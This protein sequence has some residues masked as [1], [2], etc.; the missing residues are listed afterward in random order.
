MTDILHLVA[1]EAMRQDTS[2]NPYRTGS[3]PYVAWDLRKVATARQAV[4]A[5]SRN[6]MVGVHRAPDT[7]PAPR[8]VFAWSGERT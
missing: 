5:W 3:L 1:D 7:E 4:Q 8:R 2:S 6:G